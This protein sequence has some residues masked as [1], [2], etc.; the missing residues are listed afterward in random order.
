MQNSDIKI[1]FISNVV[2]EP[3][4]IPSIESRF[5]KNTIISF[6]PVEE[7]KE[8]R[9]KINLET[10]S[11]I[12][13]WLNLDLM[14]ADSWNL[15]F[16]KT[17]VEQDLIDR[18]L[19]TCNN[20]YSDLQAYKNAYFLWFL[21]ED[22]YLKFPIVLGNLYD[23]LI[24]KINIRLTDALSKNVCFIDLKRLIAKVGVTNA[25]DQKSKYRYSKTLIKTAA[26]EI[27]KQYVIEKGITKK[28]LVLDCDNVLWGG[29]L[30]EDGIE[31][32]KLS[33]SGLGRAYQDFQRFVLSLYYHGVILA[34]CS[35]NELSDVLAMF[36]EHDGMILKENHIACFKVN[37]DSKPENIQSISKT[38]H[39]G[40]D[41]M[42][43]VDDSPIEIEA[44]KSILP[45]VMAILYER[46]AIYDK[47][48]CFNLKSN[49][50]VTDIEIRN[51]TYKTNMV[52]ETLK[53]KYD[54]YNE[55]IKALEIKTDI[56]EATPIEYGRISELTQRTNRC[57]N[58]RRYTVAEIRERVKSDTIKLYSFF[59]SDRFSDLG[60]VGAV[61]IE[62]NCLTLF[63]F[64]CRA[65]GRELEQEL[66]KFIDKK[67]KIENIKFCANDKNIDLKKTLVDIFP[68]AIFNT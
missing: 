8:E 1:G 24:D 26:E 55:F 9:H 20:L 41:S 12:V 48:S 60:L 40:L 66:L 19:F 33:T 28:C 59:A 68:N 43:F 57:T 47:L 56:H 51:K 58:G 37:W 34:V 29:I 64:S 49:I 5:G 39:I 27:H 6:I 18:I 62:K 25:Y 7:Y 53:S 31:N 2:F 17:L 35:K 44:V 4:L 45:D 36:R 11:I 67:H 61:E 52:R 32:I 42:V 13:V 38:L 10:S 46:H 50:N 54:N 23:G 3:Y 30:S 63:S 22:Y 16:T 21:F 65:L 14:F 15:L